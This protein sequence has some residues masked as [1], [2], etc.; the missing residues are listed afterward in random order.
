VP[1]L[2]GVKSARRAV[3][4][5]AMIRRIVAEN[6]AILR[7]SRARLPSSPSAA[8]DGAMLQTDGLLHSL[9]YIGLKVGCS[10]RSVDECVVVAI[11]SMHLI[12]RTQH[13]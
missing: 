5:D 7:K 1:W 11:R 2:S 6:E 4:L 9:Y 10:V 8:T 13:L 3:V 12:T